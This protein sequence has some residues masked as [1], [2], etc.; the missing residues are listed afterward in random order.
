LSGG[1]LFLPDIILFSRETQPS[2]L[3]SKRMA[4]Q[5]STHSSQIKT[6]FGPAIS[7]LTD[8]DGL[9][10]NEQLGIAGDLAFTG[11]EAGR[12]AG[13]EGFFEAFI[14]GFSLVFAIIGRLS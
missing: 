2:L 11:F 5:T 12:S 9:P 3:S 7:L 6:S 1:D 4:T 13:L 14:S 10:Q 8:S